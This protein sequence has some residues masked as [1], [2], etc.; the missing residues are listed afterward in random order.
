MTPSTP[1]SA[2]APASAPSAMRGG[3]L[4]ALTATAALAALACVLGLVEAALPP[5]VPVARIGLANVAVVVALVS[6]GSVSAVV[7]SLVRVFVVGLATGTL[8][9]P[10]FLLALAGA[11]VAWISMSAVRALIR[12]ATVLGISAVGGFAHVVAQLLVAA[13][14]AGSP[15]VLALGT[16]PLLAGLLFGLLTGFLARLVLSHTQES[17]RSGR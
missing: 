12:G 17:V 10:T 7:V 1:R 2:D 8:G 11:L 14:L 15:G 3:S 9:G 16:V 5:I 13:L 6:L 4:R